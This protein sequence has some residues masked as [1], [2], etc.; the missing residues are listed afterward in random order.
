MG[1]IIEAGKHFRLCRT[2]IKALVPPGHK[3]K[4]T[5]TAAGAGDA[6]AEAMM[7]LQRVLFLH[8]LIDRTEASPVTPRTSPPRP[9]LGLRSYGPSLTHARGL[10]AIWQ[11]AKS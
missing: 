8:P 7:V 4:A 1:G 5:F 2:Q 9:W 6:A 10:R 3:T 11:L